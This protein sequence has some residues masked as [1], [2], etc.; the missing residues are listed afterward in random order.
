MIPWRRRIL[1]TVGSRERA[2]KQTCRHSTSSA[3]RSNACASRSPG[4]VAVFA[5]E[6]GVSTESAEAL[7]QRMAA[8][9]EALCA[10][11]DR[12]RREERLVGST[13]ASGKPIKGTPAHRR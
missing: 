12:L 2:A 13:Y 1:D 5:S 9:V 6:A 10:E 3:L 7:L 8:K 11:R 4:S